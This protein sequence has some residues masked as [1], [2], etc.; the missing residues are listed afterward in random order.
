MKAIAAGVMYVSQAYLYCNVGPCTAT[1]LLPMPWCHGAKSALL[2]MLMND[3]NEACGH[4]MMM[5]MMM[6]IFV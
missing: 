3:E 2:L 6:M 5:M 4:L 1:V